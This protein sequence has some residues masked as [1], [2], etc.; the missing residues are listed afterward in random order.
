MMSL[1]IAS[2]HQGQ[3]KRPLIE[4]DPHLRSLLAE[5][6]LCLAIAGFKDIATLREAG[7][8]QAR[9]ASALVPN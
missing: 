4:P 8:E 2:V 6:D 3:Q 7:C 9:S 5:L 1:L